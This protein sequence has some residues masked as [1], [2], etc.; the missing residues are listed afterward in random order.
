MEAVPISQHDSPSVVLELIYRLKVKDV[1][2]KNVISVP[3]SSSMRE[4]Q[5]LM[6]DNTITGIPIVDNGLLSGIISMQDIIEALDSGKINQSAKDCMTQGV[7][8]LEDDMPLS[9]AINYLNKY[10]FGRFPV[11]DREQKVVGIITSSDIIRTLLVEINREVQRLEEQV[12]THEKNS[13]STERL[14]F[15][16]VRFD[17]ESAGRASTEIK[18]AL[19][20]RGIDSAI[21]RRTAIASYELEMNEVIHSIGG[22]L[23]CY[24]DADKIELI[25]KDS[26][27]GIKN[28]NE[29]MNEGFSTAND[30]IRSLGFGAGM[31]LPNTKRVADEF[32]I[33]STEKGTCVK[34][35]IYTKAKTT[36]IE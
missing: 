14:E 30:W 8:V 32:D 17:F 24:V 9:F 6:R 5:A 27:P 20:S 7:I 19:K 11:V 13:D 4:I 15:S 22:T 34:V 12:R 26:G 31:G 35:I 16:V 18:K 21:V 36:T 3:S 28:L 23:S 25:A 10:K 1:M 33:T 2:T 29:A